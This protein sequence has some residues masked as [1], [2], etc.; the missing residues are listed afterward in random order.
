VNVADITV[1][2]EYERGWRDGWL[3]ALGQ[4]WSCWRREAILAALDAG[5]PVKKSARWLSAN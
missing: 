3:A 1:Q 5:P 2:S 4:P